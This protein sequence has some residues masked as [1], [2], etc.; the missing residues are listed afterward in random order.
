MVLSP[1][2]LAVFGVFTT[3]TE[4]VAS[5]VWWS[6]V[7]MRMNYLNMVVVPATIEANLLHFLCRDL[8]ALKL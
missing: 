8:F 5:T 2:P 4:I 6:V 7:G 1:L 3:F